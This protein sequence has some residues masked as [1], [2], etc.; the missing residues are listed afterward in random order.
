[1]LRHF[2]FTRDGYVGSKQLY[3]S[4]K[5]LLN[6][7]YANV[8]EDKGLNNNSASPE[9]SEKSSADAAKNL[10]FNIFEYS[11][12]HYSI[13]VQKN[14]I[15]FSKYLKSFM[16][17]EFL[18]GDKE[19]IDESI[20][21]LRLFNVSQ[22]YPL[23]YSFLVCTHRLGITERKK[24]VKEFIGLLVNF[25]FINYRIGD[26]RANEIELLFANY[27]KDFFKINDKYRFSEKY[28]NLISELKKKLDSREIFISKFTDLTYE[29]KTRKTIMYIFDKINEY[30]VRQDNAIFSLYDSTPYDIEHWAPQKPGSNSLEY[31]LFHDDIGKVYINNI[32]NLLILH[33]ESNKVLFNK[34][35]QEKYDYIRNNHSLSSNS[36]NIVKNFFKEYNQNFDKWGK[37]Q[38]KD[39][40]KKIA[41]LCYDKI[42]K[43]Q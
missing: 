10:Y 1:M 4:L 43:F 20:A 28:K 22:V 34:T 2:Y 36:L 8:L 40:A 25:H 21:A 27:S 3:E 24:Y 33:N 19:F 26:N 15:H 29:P 13:A 32:G 6:K 39:R 12:F 7:E 9:E 17:L 18:R 11:E 38:I 42:W 31:K 41:E 5:K 37:D 35:P 16:G 30:D 14:T 23:I